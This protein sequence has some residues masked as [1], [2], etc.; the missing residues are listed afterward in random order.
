MKPIFFSYHFFG[1]ASRV[2]AKIPTALVKMK[3]N[4]GVNV[5]LRMF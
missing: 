4:V 1:K 3:F 2:F 5:Y